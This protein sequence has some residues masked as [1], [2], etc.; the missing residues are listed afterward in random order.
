M[1][2]RNF[3]PSDKKVGFV[4]KGN[5]SL[6]INDYLEAIAEIIGA[7][8]IKTFGRIKGNFGVWVKT[9]EAAEKLSDVDFLP[10]KNES[11]AM[12]PYVVPIL[13]VKLFNV[14]PFLPNDVIETELKRHGIIKAPITVEPLYGVSEKFKGIESFTR[15]TSMSFQTD[16]KL[17]EKL[18]IKLVTT[19]EESSHVIFTQVGA[20]KCFICQETKHK[21]KDCPKKAKKTEKITHDNKLNDSFHFPTVGAANNMEIE[22]KE[23]STKDENEAQFENKTDSEG[24]E[25][26][27]GKGGPSVHKSSATHTP[28]KRIRLS[29][30]SP[31]ARSD[32]HYNQWKEITQGNLK[33]SLNA[34]LHSFLGRLSNKDLET[35]DLKTLLPSTTDQRRGLYLYLEELIAALGSSQGQLKKDLRIISEKLKLCMD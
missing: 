33:P 15:T 28:Q 27:G 1:G 18:V 21:S 5:E 9:P 32:W 35:L 2:S 10:V 34:D 24:T 30:N 29:A 7:E 14:P 12:W 6:Q 13:K 11:V 19:T 16:V 23:G 26:A 17:P 31:V 22:D 3:Q 25:V 4:I 20:Q 8:S